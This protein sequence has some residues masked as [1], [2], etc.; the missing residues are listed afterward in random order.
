MK[1]FYVVTFYLPMMN[2]VGHVNTFASNTT[3]ATNTETYTLFDVVLLLKFV[4]CTYYFKLSVDYYF[5]RTFIH[6]KIN[7]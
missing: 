5:L 3:T 2:V 7:F 1:S 6:C 4:V